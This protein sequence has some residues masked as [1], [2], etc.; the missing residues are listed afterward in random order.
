MLVFWK[1]NLVFLAVPKTGTTAIEGALAPKAA[2]VL[3]EPPQIK[4]A[5]LYRYGR[6]LQPMFEQACKQNPETLAVIRHPVD[7]LSSWYRYRNRHA[8]VGH[9]NSTRNV[10][11]NEFVLEYCK[12]KPASFANV[13]S[14]TTYVFNGQ[15]QRITTYLFAYDNQP[16]LIDFLEKRLNTKI[17]LK[18]LNVSPTIPAV[19]SPE[20]DAHFRA[21]KPL[22]FAAYAEA[23]SGSA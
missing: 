7:W 14:Q 19:I 16:A 23:M 11:F 2:M 8:L 18:Q 17:E 6:F 13:G 5:P 9:E 20:V 10:N 21:T 4:H 22:E 3:R 15:G 12:E 1:E